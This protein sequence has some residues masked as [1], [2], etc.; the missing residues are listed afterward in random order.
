MRCLAIIVL[1][2][3]LGCAWGLLMDWLWPYTWLKLAPEV[4]GA[5]FIGLALTLPTKRWWLGGKR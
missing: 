1:A 2:V 5:A 4:I 3:G